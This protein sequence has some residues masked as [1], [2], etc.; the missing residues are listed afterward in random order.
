MRLLGIAFCALSRGYGPD[1]VGFEGVCKGLDV[2]DFSPT[3]LA[4]GVLTI[5]IENRIVF[6]GGGGSPG[7]TSLVPPMIRTWFPQLKNSKI[8]IPN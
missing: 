3:R 2:H 1:V 5:R 7:R 8:M 6:P 4:F